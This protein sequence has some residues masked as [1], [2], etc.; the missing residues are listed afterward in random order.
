MIQEKRF[1]LVQP[2]DSIQIKV[3]GGFIQHQQS[4]FHEQGSV[5]TELS[6]NGHSDRLMQHRPHPAGL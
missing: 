4:G 1:V 5:G 6:V 2:D 3:V